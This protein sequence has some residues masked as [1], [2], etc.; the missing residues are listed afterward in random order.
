MAVCGYCRSTL[1]RHDVNLENL[2]VMAELAE[3]RSPFALRWRGQYRK[4]G[5]QLI[6]RLQLQYSEGYWNEWYAR[7][8]DGRLGWVSEGSGLCYV[9]FEKE[10]KT[11]LPPFDAFKPGLNAKLGDKV[12]TVTDIE[13]S[14]C[15]AIEGELPF[16][17]APGYEAPAVDLRADEQFASIDFSEEQPRVYLGEAVTLDALIDPSAPNKPAKEK[18]ADAHGFKCTSCGAPI[19]V[20]SPDTKAVG[21]G[22]CGAVVDVN[23][24]DLKILS[25]ALKTL[26]EP[27]LPVGIQGKL[28]GRDYAI[29]GYL[30]RGTSEGDTHYYWD[31]YLLHSKT[32]GYA[33]LIESNG[34]WSLG[35]PVTRQPTIRAA[36]RPLA[37]FLDRDYRHFA[38]YPAEVVRVIGEFNW[39]VSVGETVRVDDYI[40]PPYML[41]CEKSDR[42]I[43]WTMAEYLEPDA[44][45]Q[46]FKLKTAL[47]ERVGVGANQPAPPGSG[48]GSTR[49]WVA[50]T[51][52][53]LLAFVL[54]AGFL[55]TADRTIVWQGMLKV[56]QGLKTET[57]NAPVVHVAG[58]PGNLRL[59]QQTN[60]E[61]RWLDSNVS[62][63]NQQTGQV[64]QA[65]QEISYYHGEDSD[66]SW[67]EGDRD[68]ETVFNDVPPGD[69]TLD[70]EAEVDPAEGSGDVTDR[71]QLVRNVPL[72]GNF[73]LLLV[74]LLI[75]PLLSRWGGDSFEEQRWSESDY[76]GGGDD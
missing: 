21:C 6:G 8:D 25:G 4:A 45:R 58:R 1:V 65:Q 64:F 67:S 14:T 18:R 70:A 34:H 29:I 33:W 37:R 52:F 12:F 76:G 62:L 13:N 22:H 48:G 56:D 69:Y 36:A 32:A 47:P 28:G 19:T 20:T 16:R 9:T 53:V 2:G 17:A 31:E 11:Q 68:A 51:A 43:T 39:R 75:P 54:Q 46:A 30:K 55:F 3:D 5:F 59:K 74:L 73:W 10:L 57:I 50:F 7:F 72:W 42:E 60:L 38:N 35:K 49:Y 26:D 40:A 63:V 23:D 61:N 27:F 24:P 66:G 15:V 71:L 44:I 41:S